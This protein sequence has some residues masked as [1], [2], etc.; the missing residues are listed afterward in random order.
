LDIRFT[1]D[2]RGY[3]GDL[4]NWLEVVFDALRMPL[5]PKEVPGSMFG[6]ND[7]LLYVLV[8]D[9]SLIRTF[10]VEAI[11]SPYSP[12]EYDLLLTVHVVPS[13]ERHPALDRF[14]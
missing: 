2:E 10:C 3:S 11:Q 4:D 5:D 8:E 9:D 14:R 13:D 1:G 6:K 12:A 7:E